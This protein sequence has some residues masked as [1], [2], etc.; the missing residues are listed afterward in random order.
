[1]QGTVHKVVDA[2]SVSGPN[3]WWL[4]PGHFDLNGCGHQGGAEGDQEDGN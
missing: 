2:K 3:V 1:M 4:D